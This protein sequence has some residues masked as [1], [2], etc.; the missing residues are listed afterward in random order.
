MGGCGSTRLFNLLVMIDPD[1]LGLA[2]T[3]ATTKSLN[4]LR[5]LADKA[6]RETRSLHDLFNDI[7][8]SGQSRIIITA[9]LPGQGPYPHG[10]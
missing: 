7:E 1:A 6:S 9:Y 5:A 8:R 3:L 2:G 10:S 4:G